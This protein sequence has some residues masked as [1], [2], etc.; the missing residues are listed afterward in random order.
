[1]ELRKISD[2]DIRSGKPMGAILVVS[3]AAGVILAWVLY[4][5]LRAATWFGV[6][7]GAV[8]FWF[9]WFAWLPRLWNRLVDFL[10]K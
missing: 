7:G 4:D 8:L 9:A 2:Q 5:P 1:M 6:A 10:Q 3:I